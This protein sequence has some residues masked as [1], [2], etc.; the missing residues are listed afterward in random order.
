MIV[1]H[2]HHFHDHI[3]YIARSSGHDRN[4]DNLLIVFM[5]HLRVVSSEDRNKESEI[6]SPQKVKT[7]TPL[8][9]C[10]RGHLR[11]TLSRKSCERNK[12]PQRVDVPKS[13]NQISRDLERDRLKLQCPRR[14]SREALS[15]REKHNILD[16]I[17]SR[18]RS[19]RTSGHV[20]SKSQIR[21]RVVYRF[22]MSSHIAVICELKRNDSK[23]RLCHHDSTH[24]CVVRMKI[25]QRVEYLHALCS[26][27]IPF[28][29]S[30]RLQQ[31]VTVVRLAARPFA[32]TEKSLLAFLLKPAEAMW[33][34][35]NCQS[36]E[37]EAQMKV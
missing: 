18:E 7:P 30:S 2:H 34:H 22:V 3:S 16:S 20:L 36:R 5:D 26:E 10:P 19:L 17:C 31:P 27:S 6:P 37:N 9:G 14:T 29:Q 23:A 8:A 4:H 13:V 33:F 35:L 21:L 15:T 25:Q 11:S 28:V 12:A 1:L 24:A 32:I